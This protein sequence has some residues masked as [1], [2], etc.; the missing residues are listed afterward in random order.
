MKEIEIN[1]PIIKDTAFFMVSGRFYVL[2]EITEEQFEE[3]RQ[4]VQ[5]D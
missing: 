3:W 4:S 1:K 5:R 2:H